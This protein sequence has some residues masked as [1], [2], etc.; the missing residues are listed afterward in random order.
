[1]AGKQNGSH[2]IG[3]DELTVFV[4]PE[5]EQL[6]QLVAGARAQLVELEVN[7][8]KKN[9]AWTWC[10]RRYSDSCANIIKSATGYGSWWITGGSFWI[11]S[12]AATR[13]QRNRRN[14][15]LSR[16]ERN[17]I[18]ITKNWQQWRAKRKS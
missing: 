3:Q 10:K 5:L 11:H 2:K 16:P 1:M 14:K 15:I 6:R 12:R 9:R 18:K 7:I 17:R 13:K 4:S 8:P